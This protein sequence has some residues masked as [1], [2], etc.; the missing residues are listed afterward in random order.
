MKCEIYTRFN[1]LTDLNKEN[2][3]KNLPIASAV[4]V[5]LIFATNAIFFASSASFTAPAA[6]KAGHHNSVAGHHAKYI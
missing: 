2:I 3:M 6:S 1:E 4:I 5:S